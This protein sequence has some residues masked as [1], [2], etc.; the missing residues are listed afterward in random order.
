MIWYGKISCTSHS[1][2]KEDTEV[3]LLL[4][5]NQ[6]VL[7]TEAVKLWLY[8]T[9]QRTQAFCKLSCIA[10][11]GRSYDPVLLMRFRKLYIL[12]LSF[13]D[14]PFWSTASG[15]CL[16]N[17][18]SYVPCNRYTQTFSPLCS[19]YHTF[20]LPLQHMAANSKDSIPLWSLMRRRV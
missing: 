4:H 18:T 9:A 8:T 16:A 19:K 12:S 11:R 2:P 13:S 6:S 3:C 14:N 7:T 17:P 1:Y 20:F 5:D 15:Q 10:S